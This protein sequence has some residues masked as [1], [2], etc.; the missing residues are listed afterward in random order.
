MTGKG[1][2]KVLL[3]FIPVILSAFLFTFLDD[4]FSINRYSN[5]P[6]CLMGAA[7]Q[8]TRQQQPTEFIIL[9]ISSWLPERREEI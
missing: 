4:S 5:P 1:L 3:V 6:S 7:K 9:L 2:K 8:T